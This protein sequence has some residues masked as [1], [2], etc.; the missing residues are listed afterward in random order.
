M[1]FSQIDKLSEF[2]D[3]RISKQIFVSRKA[4]I[5]NSVPLCDAALTVLLSV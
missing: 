2:W 4:E 1:H 5:A 3:F